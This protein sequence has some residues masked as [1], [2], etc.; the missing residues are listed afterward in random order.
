MIVKLGEVKW[1]KQKQIVGCTVNLVNTQSNWN[2]CSLGLPEDH[3][4]R[5]SELPDTRKRIFATDSRLPLVSGCF[6]GF[7]TL[8]FPDLIKVAP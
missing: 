3:A 4:T 8:A 1:L 5:I 7:N 6:Q 2:L